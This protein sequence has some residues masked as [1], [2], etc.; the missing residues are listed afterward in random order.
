MR[1]SL[2]RPWFIRLAAVLLA[3]VGTAAGADELQEGRDYALLSPV[4][5]TSNPGKIVVTEFFSYECPHCF[6]LFPSISAWAAKLP[7]DVV[8]ERV[9]VG[10][11]RASWTAIAQAFY[12]LQ[13]MGKAEKLDSPIFNAIHTQNVML[14]NESN[15]TDWV[16]KQGVNAKEFTAAYNSFGVKSSMS[17]VDQLVKSYKVEGVPALFVDGKYIVSA[18]GIK[19][20][21][22]M[23]ARADKLIAKVRAERAAKK[24]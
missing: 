5:P 12:A 20:Y 16:A 10:F 17:R 1:E 24:S 14:T 9:P 15:I 6:Q 3:C 18:S 19:G 4:Q 11:G 7:K 13:A 2:I 21:D 23:L 8:F 22:E